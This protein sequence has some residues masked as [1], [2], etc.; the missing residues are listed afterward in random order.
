MKVINATPH[1]IVVSEESMY[2]G[3][4]RSKTY[5]V[6]DLVIR[7]EVEEFETEPLDGFTV[8]GTFPCG[9]ENLPP[10]HPDTMYIVSAIVLAAAKSLDREDCVAPNTKM[11]KRNRYGDII[12][13]T[14]FVR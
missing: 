12:S 10:Y 13:V 4:F 8:M 3:I 6:S 9:I 14:G 5:P 1:P 2:Q 11:A 7:L